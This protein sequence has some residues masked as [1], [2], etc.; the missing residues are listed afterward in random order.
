MKKGLANVKGE[1][2]S[3]E[4]GVRGRVQKRSGFSLISGRGRKKRLVCWLAFRVEK[5]EESQ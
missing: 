1:E 3:F 5:R 4:R 2:R